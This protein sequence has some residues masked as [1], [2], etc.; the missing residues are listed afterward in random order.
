MQ[1]MVAGMR[2]EAAYFAAEGGVRGGYFV[3]NLNEPPQMAAIAEPWFLWLNATVEFLPVM[4]PED[5][6]RAA[7]VIAAAAKTWG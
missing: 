4:L 6:A 2:A 1:E 7:P 5:L 3:V